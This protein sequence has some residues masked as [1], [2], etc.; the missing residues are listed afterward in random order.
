MSGSSLSECSNSSYSFSL[1]LAKYRAKALCVG[2]ALLIFLV[3]AGTPAIA[4]STLT[5]ATLS[6]GNQPV[7]VPSAVKTVVTFKNAQAVP[8]TI[9]SIT[10]SGGVAPVDYRW[11]GNCPIIPA[12]WVLTRA[13]ALLLRVRRLLSWQKDLLSKSNSP[14]PFCSPH[15]ALKHRD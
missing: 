10:I 1:K 11:G 4:Q 3:V 6:F 12:R 13:A 2:I 15:A 8:L 7:G 14:S 9:S 5:P